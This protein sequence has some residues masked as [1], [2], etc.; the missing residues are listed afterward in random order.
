MACDV[1]PLLDDLCGLALAFGR[2]ERVTLHED[3]RR[4]ESDSTHTVMLGL[5]ACEI[6]RFGNDP[7]RHQLVVA[8]RV[9]D[10]STWRHPDREGREQLEDRHLFDQGRVAELCLVH[11]LLEAEAGDTDTLDASAEALARKAEAEAAAAETLRRRFAGR[12]PWLLRRLD[13]YHDQMTPEARLVCYLDKVVPGLTHAANRCAHPKARGMTRREFA[14]AA[15]RQRAELRAR[16][17]ELTPLVDPLLAA[18]V[19]AAQ[20]AW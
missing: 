13:E 15:E 1:K 19:W 12:A 4:R 5:V 6:A 7:G 18:V 10:L 20:E 16:F 11:D 9:V 14:A 2:V 17:P 8:G 3:G